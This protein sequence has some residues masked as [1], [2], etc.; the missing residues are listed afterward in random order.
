MR[1]E[2]LRRSDNG[3]E[4]T[5]AFSLSRVIKLRLTCP[6]PPEAPATTATGSTK[7]LGASQL[8]VRVGHTGFE[9]HVCGFDI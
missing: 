7:Y 4:K 2:V 3:W 1:G 9:S 8:A 5:L 6:I